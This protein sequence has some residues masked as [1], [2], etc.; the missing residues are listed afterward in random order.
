MERL[1]EEEAIDVN[2]T[3]KLKPIDL[4][5]ASPKSYIARKRE[6]ELWLNYTSVL[7]LEHSIVQPEPSP[8][9]E[10]EEIPPE[11]V[12]TIMHTEETRAGLESQ[13]ALMYQVLFPEVQDATMMTVNSVAPAPLQD[14][15]VPNQLPDQFHVQGANNTEVQAAITSVETT[16]EIKPAGN[17]FVE[18]AGEKPIKNTARRGKRKKLT[19]VPLLS[20]EMPPWGAEDMQPIT[21]VV[22]APLNTSLIAEPLPDEDETKEKPPEVEEES[23]AIEYMLQLEPPTHISRIQL[24]GSTR[25]SW[26]QGKYKCIYKAVDS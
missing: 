12:A 11:V 19:E 3:L 7:E 17:A 9:Q 24:R 15:L 4:K 20:E 6:H 10:T 5:I 23:F 22:G 2:K 1:V 25:P 26:F 13:P 14:V 16:G 8:D 18:T 21:D